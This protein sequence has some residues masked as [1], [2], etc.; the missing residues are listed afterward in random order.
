MSYIH[1]IG[2]IEHH[3]GLNSDCIQVG[4]HLIMVNGNSDSTLATNVFSVDVRLLKLCNISRNKA[5]HFNG[6]KCFHPLPSKLYS[7]AV[8]LNQSNFISVSTGAL[9]NF[10]LFWS[11]FHY[12]TLRPFFDNIAVNKNFPGENELLLCPPRR[13]TAQ[14]SLF[15]NKCFGY[16]FSAIS[17]KNYVFN[18]RTNNSQRLEMKLF[19]LKNFHWNIISGHTTTS[20]EGSCEFNEMY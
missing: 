3:C 20:S 19:Q 8:L 4:I 16:G 14:Y 5:I 1:E 18:S 10:Q 15:I 13:R 9:A 6:K 2:S 12:I 11:G 7:T 17:N